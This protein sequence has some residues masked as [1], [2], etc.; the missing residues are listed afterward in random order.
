LISWLQQTAPALH[1][2]ES[3]GN[4]IN[5][6]IGE[7]PL[8]RHFIASFP[9]GPCEACKKE[10]AEAHICA[11]HLGEPAPLQVAHRRR[12]LVPAESITQPRQNETSQRTGKK[13]VRGSFMPT[14]QTTRGV[15]FPTPMLKSRARLQLIMRKLPNED[16][17]LER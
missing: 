14:T 16:F 1:E 10:E 11:K 5:W 8:D 3:R 6:I 13:D 2:R 15:T 17:Y 12:D 7:G 4:N 9:D